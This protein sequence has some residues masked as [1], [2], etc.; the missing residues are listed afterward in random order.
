[1]L[2]GQDEIFPS[3]EAHCLDVSS[4]KCQTVAKDTRI[5]RV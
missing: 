3:V 4:P 2:S 1:M 5:L